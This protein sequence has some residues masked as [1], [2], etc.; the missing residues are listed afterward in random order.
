MD[1]MWNTKDLWMEPKM[2]WVLDFD[3]CPKGFIVQEPLGMSLF[4]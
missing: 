2:V 4:Y 3:F 1:E